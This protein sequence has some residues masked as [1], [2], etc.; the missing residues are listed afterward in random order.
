MRLSPIANALPIPNSSPKIERG[1][2]IREACRRGNGCLSSVERYAIMR[3][4]EE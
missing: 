1:E 3:K 4:F 2:L